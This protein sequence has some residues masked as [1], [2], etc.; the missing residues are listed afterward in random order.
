MKQV[1]EYHNAWG[2][3]ASHFT[4]KKKRK[5]VPLVI[6][7]PDNRSLIETVKNELRFFSKLPIYEISAYSQNPFEEAK[8]L[9]SIMNN[10]VEAF[11]NITRKKDFIVI[12]TPFSLLRKSTSY[13]DFE[14]NV[15][16]IKKGEIYSREDLLNRLDKLGY[17]SVEFA[18]DCGEYNVRGGIVDVFPIGSDDPV[19]VEYFDDE[20]EHLFYYDNNSQVRKNEIDEII[21]LPASDFL[22]STEDFMKNIPEG[23]GKDKAESFGKFAGYHWYAPYFKSKQSTIFDFIK[24][25]DVVSFI[26]SLDGSLY[27]AYDI[28]EGCI[29]LE[30]IC[31]NNELLLNNFEKPKVVM[32]Y[33]Y[34]NNYTVITETSDKTDSVQLEYISTKI[35]FSYE[36]RNLYQSMTSAVEILFKMLED[37]K[38]IIF[39]TESQKFIDVFNQ[40]LRDYDL[41]PIEVNGIEEIKSPGIYVYKNRITGGYIDNESNLVFINDI[42]IFGFTKRKAKSK[43]KDAFNTKLTDLEEGDYVVHVNHGIGIYQGIKHLTIAGSEADFLSILYDENDILYVPLYSITQIQK[44]VGLNA[45][46]PKLSSLK[47]SAWQKIKKNAKDSA[48]KIA[49]DLLRL[50]AERKAKKGFSFNN[51]DGSLIESFESAFEFEETEDQLSAI[52]DVYRDMEDEIPMERLVCGDVGFGKT[53]V[54]MRA[55]CKAVAC[56]KQ[57]AVLVPTTILAR[58]HYETF[59]KRFKNLPVVVD[60]ISRYRTSSENKSI[61]NDMADGKIDILIGTHKILSKELEFKD[62]G[63]LIIDEEQR[64]GVS[65]KEKIA[66]MKRNVDTVTMSATPIPRTLQLSLSGIRDMSIIETPPANRLPVV[67]KVIKGL[68]ERVKAIRLELDRGGQIFFLHNKVSNIQEIVWELKAQLPH[69]RIDF[70]HGQMDA[71]TMEKI[72]TSFYNGEIDV[73][74]ATTIIENG[75]DIPNVNTIVINNAAHFGLSQLYQLKGRVGRSDR[76]GYCYLAVDDFNRLNPIAQ[77]RLSIVQQLSDLGSGFK[78]AMYDLQI[79]GAGNILGAEQSGFV[80]RVGYE[81][82]VAM[83][84]EAVQEMKGE[85]E[86]IGETEINSNIAYFIPADYIENPRVRF[87]FYR[88][89]AGIYDIDTLISVLEEIEIGY[90]EL[91]EEVTNLAF[92]VIIKNLASRLGIERIIL[93]K[94]GTAKIKFVKNSSINPEIILK[95]VEGSRIVFRFISEYEIFVGYEGPQALRAIANFF[96][97]L[98]SLVEEYKKMEL[99]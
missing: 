7:L 80:V 61:Y 95:A 1:L 40:F 50:Y 65:H 79:R 94:S 69:A 26:N 22:I 10:R 25:Y 44:Y 54:A 67:V 18:S 48:K 83:I 63:L 55:A 99:A 16:K 66:A 27:S 47:S 85:G 34:A 37:R 96:E 71:K 76:R 90:G 53:E 19:R 86:N 9:I 88:R 74:V 81:L 68:E 4:L 13:E 98:Y 87:D 78:I 5:D 73:L 17:I 51:D 49:E 28:I 46:K 23:I 35:D 24:N 58:Q 6:V 97:K 92:I 12:V 43:K 8:P 15:L 45:S 57:V 64:F 91:R 52:Q 33:I 21:F 82:Y 38:K 42:D 20:V 60:Y 84:E 56:G 31:G 14:K 30:N 3:S 93:S 29:P 2:A 72:L 11:Y 41:F 77:K 39:S 89:L 62:L 59:S 36:K 70:A 75:I 32:D